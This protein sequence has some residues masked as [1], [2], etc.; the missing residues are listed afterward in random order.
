MDEKLTKVKKWLET[1]ERPP[2]MKDTE[3][4][5]FTCY[6]VEFFVTDGRLW[7]KDRKGHHK[8]VVPQERRIFLVS[9]AHNNVRHHGFYATNA[10]LTERYWWPGMA[11]D[12]ADELDWR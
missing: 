5:T 8:V 11:Q 4:K 10:L 2:D 12:I 9:S 3:Y 1:I 6:C 7:R